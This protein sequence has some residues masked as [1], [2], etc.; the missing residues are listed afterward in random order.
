MSS[1]WKR[2]REGFGERGRRDGGYERQTEGDE[3]ERWGEGGREGGRERK[4]E[5]QK[6]KEGRVREERVGTRA[7]GTG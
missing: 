5:T 7:R 6:G 1:L 4:A 3:R 2:W